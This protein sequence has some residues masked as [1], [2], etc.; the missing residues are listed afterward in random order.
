M[1]FTPCRP[2]TTQCFYHKRHRKH[3][4]HTDPDICTHLFRQSNFFTYKP[5]RELANYENCSYSDY[6]QSDAYYHINYK[7][8]KRIDTPIRQALPTC[9]AEVFRIRRIGCIA[10]PTAFMTMC[11]YLFLS[12][13]LVP[14]AAKER[15]RNPLP[16]CE[17]ISYHSDLSVSLVFTILTHRSVWY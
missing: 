17:R 9:F 13:A 16:R 6:R 3:R 11:H 4:R 1:H 15:G 12:F 8:S 7:S 5:Y 14:I 2:Q 10:N